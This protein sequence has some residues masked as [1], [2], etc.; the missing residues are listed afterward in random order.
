MNKLVLSLITIILMVGCSKSEDAAAPTPNT[1]NAGNEYYAEYGIPDQNLIQPCTG[2]KDLVRPVSKC[3]RRSTNTQV[4]VALCYNLE[5]VTMILPSPSGQRI[6]S[7]TGGRRLETCNEGS[8]EII[9]ISFVCNPGFILLNNRCQGYESVG[10]YV[11]Q[12]DQS[13]RNQDGLKMLLTIGN[14]HSVKTKDNL[15]LIMLME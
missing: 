2:E 12:K 10:S 4:N 7:I 13:Y 9:D 8:I 11:V 15:K 1:T 14:D 6:V 5:P 3:V